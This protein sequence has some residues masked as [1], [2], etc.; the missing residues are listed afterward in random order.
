MMPHAYEAQRAKDKDG[1]ER[2]RQIEKGRTGP[3]SNYIPFSLAFL[4]K[5]KMPKNM[6][7]RIFVKIP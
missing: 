3:S 7:D 1:E 4:D 6:E 2:R 5:T